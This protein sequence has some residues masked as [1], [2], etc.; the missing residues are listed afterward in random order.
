[1]QEIQRWDASC[2]NVF[3]SSTGGYILYSDHKKVVEE[4]EKH[5]L[6]LQRGMSDLLVRLKEA[7]DIAKYETN[8][9]DELI[10]KFIEATVNKK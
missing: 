3:P 4:Q 8:K 10:S 9:Y 7:E 5:I 2:L 1:M 6:A